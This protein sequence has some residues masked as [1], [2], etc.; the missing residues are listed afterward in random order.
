MAIHRGEVYFV[1]LSPTI[2]REQAGV[3][4]VLVLSNDALNRRPLVI[5]VVPGTKGSNEPIDYVSNV[6]VP[7][8]EGGLR[9]E[10]V[11]LTLQI[12]ALDHSRFR[13]PP[14]G[15][16]SPSQMDRI[17][18]ALTWTQGMSPAPKGKP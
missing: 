2:G 15:S 1:D 10:T 9:E 16:L 12:R 6:R 3:R 8:G 18:K 17:E 13:K 7:A 11:F 4:P 5:V 14:S